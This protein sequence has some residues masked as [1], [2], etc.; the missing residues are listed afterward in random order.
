RRSTVC[1]VRAEG[2]SLPCRYRRAEGAHQLLDKGADEA[3]SALLAQ[4]NDV[5]G[6]L[7][8]LLSLERNRHQAP[9]V[10]L[11]HHGPPRQDRHPRTATDEVAHGLE[12][13][14]G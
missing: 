11:A 3:G 8:E 1:R 12:R 5:D 7:S 6:G 4:G 14:G 10:L 13:V 9:H 2:K